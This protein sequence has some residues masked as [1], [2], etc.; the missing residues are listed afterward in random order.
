MTSIQVQRGKQVI[1]SG[2]LFVKI[3]FLGSTPLVFINPSTNSEWE[4]VR[5]CSGLPLRPLSQCLPSRTL[6]A[7]CGLNGKKANLEL[8]AWKTKQQ[9]SSGK[10]VLLEEFPSVFHHWGPPLLFPLSF[11]LPPPFPFLPTAMPLP[12]PLPLASLYHHWR[13]VPHLE[14][15]CCK[16]FSA[17]KFETTS[18]KLVRL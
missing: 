17:A 14:S 8:A 6:P 5:Q 16:G 10:H 15:C 3:S 11:P 13:L 4:P 2:A 9:Q 18:R 12:L 1:Q 7:K